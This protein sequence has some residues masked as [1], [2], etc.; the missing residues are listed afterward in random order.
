MRG[1]DSSVKSENK[2]AKWCI[3]TLC[4]A[5]FGTAM[6]RTDLVFTMS[7]LN[8]LKAKTLNGAI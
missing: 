2:Y 7:R 8:I 5:M 4:E 3:L 6:R 1:Y